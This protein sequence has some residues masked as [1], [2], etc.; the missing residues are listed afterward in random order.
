[1]NLILHLDIDGLAQSGEEIII[2]STLS[3]LSSGSQHSEFQFP[4]VDI[5][6]IGGFNGGWTQAQI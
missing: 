2:F 4:P 1:M 6:F 5:W 3:I